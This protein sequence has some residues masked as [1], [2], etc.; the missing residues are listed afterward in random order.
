MKGQ[1]CSLPEGY[2]T[3]FSGT[4]LFAFIITCVK[5]K[6][7]L[8]SAKFFLPMISNNELSITLSTQWS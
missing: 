1:K 3:K 5:F 8:M 6:L 4:T 2:K 7:K